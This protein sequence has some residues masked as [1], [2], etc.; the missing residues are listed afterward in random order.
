V[1]TLRLRGRLSYPL[2][3]RLRPPTGEVCVDFVTGDPSRGVLWVS[4]L[5][6][7]ECS[8]RRARWRTVE[9]VFDT[10]RFPEATLRLYTS[11]ADGAGTWSGSA[12]LTLSG[13]SDRVDV[14]I[15]QRPPDTENTGGHVGLTLDT[16]LSRHDF[17]AANST[18]RL[19]AGIRLTLGLALSMAC[20]W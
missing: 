14:R 8:R 5:P 9:H 12:M 3:V 11:S 6:H 10:T 19:R 15:R 7:P 1:A 18:P 20:P 4:L 17:T 16:R 13:L 2:T